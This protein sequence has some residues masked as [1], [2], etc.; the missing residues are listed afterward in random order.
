MG[1]PLFINQDV[2]R[3]QVTMEDSAL[4]SVV[5][6]LSNL[7]NNLGSRAGIGGVLVESFVEAGSLD[8]LHAKKMRSL[9]LADFV[10]RHDMR[11]IEL[12]DSLGFVLKAESSFSVANVPDLISLIATGRLSAT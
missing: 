1:L 12:C 10:N 9:M 5:N 2:R 6:G 4:M 11:M 8:E 7:G 3:L